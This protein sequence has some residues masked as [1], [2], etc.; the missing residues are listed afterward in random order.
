MKIRHLCF[1]TDFPTR[2]FDAMDQ[3]RDHDA[4]TVRPNM[5]LLFIQDFFRSTGGNKGFKDMSH[6]G[7]IDRVVSFPSEK[8]PAPPAP[9]WTLL[10]GSSCPVCQNVSTSFTR[11]ARSRPRSTTRDGSRFP[12][13]EAAISRQGQVP[14]RGDARAAF[15]FQSGALGSVPFYRAG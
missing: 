12:Q 6:N 5:G 9:N 13:V 14:P 3:A 15:R 11:W 7:V 10:T 8:V 4:E 2:L 1:I